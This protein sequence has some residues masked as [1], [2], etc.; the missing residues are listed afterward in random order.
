MRRSDPR[1]KEDAMAKR[2]VETTIGGAKVLIEDVSD[3]TRS[4]AM[5]DTAGGATG[6]RRV[7][8]LMGRMGPVI[9]GLADMG[10][11]ALAG[12]KER[13]PDEVTLGMSMGYNAELDAWVI[14]GDASLSF[15]VEVKWKRDAAD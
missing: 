8:D 14:K 15:N 6:N 3:G 11:K 4:S 9:A 13:R 7:D 5:R 10:E 2:Y 1:P 12:L